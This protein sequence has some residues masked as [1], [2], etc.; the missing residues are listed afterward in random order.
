MIAQL[1]SA[2]TQQ[3][4]CI[5]QCFLHARILK[6]KGFVKLADEEYKESIEAMKHSDMLVERILSLGGIPNM[7]EVGAIAI[8]ET[9]DAIL[10]H[11]L[12][13]KEAVKAQLQQALEHCRANRDKASE[14]LIAKILSTVEE[15]ID[16]IHSQREQ[17]AAA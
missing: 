1:N 16:Y 3:L 14:A 17:L 12:A 8:G 7:Q 5:N 2:L 10:E 4:A 13:L 9:V 6:H 15:H 11:D